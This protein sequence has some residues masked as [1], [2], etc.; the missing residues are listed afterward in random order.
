MFCL[1]SFHRILFPPITLNILGGGH[2][3][4]SSSDGILIRFDQEERMDRDIIGGMN[5]GNAA[6]KFEFNFELSV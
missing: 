4:R 6:L 5:Y 1:R 3:D 2:N